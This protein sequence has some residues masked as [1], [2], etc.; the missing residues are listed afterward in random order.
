MQLGNVQFLF[1]GG[2]KGLSGASRA[3]RNMY[4][5]FVNDHDQFVAILRDATTMLNTEV[6][7][8]AQSPKKSANDSDT[9]HKPIIRISWDKYETALLFKAY[10]SITRGEDYK[11]EAVKLSNTLR[12]YAINRGIK[13]NETYRNVNGMNMHLAQVQYL[14]T[15]GNKGLPSCS[16]AIKEMYELYQSDYDAY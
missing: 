2:E 8:N 14:F 10:E 1:T 7:S 11:S 15:G 12:Q 9:T 16:K 13:I 5:I 3:I 6:E 4:D